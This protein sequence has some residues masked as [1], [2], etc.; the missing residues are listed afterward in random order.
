MDKLLRDYDEE[1]V[2]TKLFQGIL[3]RDSLVFLASIKAG[4]AVNKT[5][6]KTGHSFLHVIITFAS[7]GIERK[8]IPMVYQLSN[9]GANLDLQDSTG[10]S[11]LH[12]AIKK[13]LIEIMLALVKC[14]C[15]CDK[16]VEMELLRGLRGPSCFEM[17]SAYQK[18]APGY[19]DAVENDKAFKTNVLVK[20]WCRI[21][22]SRKNKSLIE[23]AKE[24]NAC[25]KIIKML[26]QNEASIEFAHATIAGDEERMRY[27]LLHH[28]VDLETKDLSHRE[29]YF[30]PYSPLS[31]Y[32]AAILYGHKH[33]L[34][35]LKNPE[36]V[37]QEHRL[38][39]NRPTD[40][41]DSVD[42]SAVCVVL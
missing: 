35:M 4:E 28:E 29:S 31:L 2:K 42:G 40:T 34:H 21:N 12:F 19:W 7:Q 36:E 20:S 16:D 24:Q 26:L 14:G 13:S 33:I 39:S 30:E 25:E 18:F 37:I 6:P 23:Y 11:P 32:G 22:I 8:Y 9:A 3:S 41:I 38:I 1:F 17:T 27:L 15:S 5:C 10:T